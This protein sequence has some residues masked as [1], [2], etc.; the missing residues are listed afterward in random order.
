VIDAQSSL[1]SR[2][3][4]VSQ[5]RQPLDGNPGAPVDS[6]EDLLET[7]VLRLRRLAGEV[8]DGDDRA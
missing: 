4:G 6:G 5:H 1:A 2:D 3:I 7:L 8:V